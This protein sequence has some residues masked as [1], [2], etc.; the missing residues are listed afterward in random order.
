MS[1][2]SDSK[3]VLIHGTEWSWADV[4]LQVEACESTTWTPRR[5]KPRPALVDRE[6]RTA[7]PY[8]G[9]PFDPAKTELVEGAWDH[10]HCEICGW[11]LMEV[12][13]PARA[14]GYVSPNEDWICTECHDQF[15][16]R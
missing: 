7:T 12:D 4:R 11:K 2:E 16:T 3:V 1:S 14:F 6:G 5:W 9:Q 15:L 13:D 10:D 8:G